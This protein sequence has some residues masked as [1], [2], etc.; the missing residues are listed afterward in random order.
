MKEKKIFQNKITKKRKSDDGNDS[1]K[2]QKCNSNEYVASVLK[3]HTSLKSQKQCR[4]TKVNRS[5]TSPPDS[6]NKTQSRTKT[7]KAP[8]A[9][10]KEEIQRNY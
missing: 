5:L 8:F 3:D 4:V 10:Y 2:R 1:S 9:V 6:T 7:Q